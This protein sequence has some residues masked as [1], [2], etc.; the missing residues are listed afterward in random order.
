MSRQNKNNSIIFLTT[1]SVYLGLVL[2]GGAMSPV[3]AQ[4]ATR[5]SNV[6]DEI[7]VKDDLDRKPSDEELKKLSSAIANYFEDLTSFIEDLKKLHGIEKFDLDF[8]TFAFTEQSFIPCNYKG[9]P[10]PRHGEISQRIDNRWLEPAITDASYKTEHW[11]FLSD[12][13]PHDKFKTAT[14]A[15]IDLSYDKSEFKYEVFITKDSPQKAKQLAKNFIQSLKLYKPDEEEIVVGK[16]HE[17]TSFKSEN[18]Q[19]FIIT[20]LPRGSLDE[21]FKQNAKADNQ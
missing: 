11:D 19:V 4:A 9:D 13:L 17:K 5:N 10:V 18:N 20:R 3:L 6:Q 16:L 8:D 21:L 12:C 14:S 15:G 1:L 2:V 7:E